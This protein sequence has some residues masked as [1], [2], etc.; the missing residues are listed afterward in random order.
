MSSLIVP[1]VTGRTEDV[2]HVNSYRAIS[3]SSAISCK[4]AAQIHMS[5]AKSATIH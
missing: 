3:I 2:S 4:M 5:T 1:F